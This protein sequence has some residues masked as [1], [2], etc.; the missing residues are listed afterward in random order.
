MVLSGD[1]VTIQVDITDAGEFHC[2]RLTLNPQAGPAERIEVMF[3]ATALVELIHKCST[4]LCEWQN[5]T[6][7]DLLARS[8]VQPLTEEQ[9]REL[10]K[11]QV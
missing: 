4:A 8:G 11:R 1:Q 9:Y 7:E 10:A 3:H 5:R 2:F 6:T